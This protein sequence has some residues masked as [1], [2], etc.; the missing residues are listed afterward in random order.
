MSDN[1][2]APPPPPGRSAL[3]AHASEPPLRALRADPESDSGWKTVRVSVTDVQGI[4]A[5]ATT[6]LSAMLGVP[7]DRH[8][9]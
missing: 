8:L 3:I 7:G 6:D 4:A 5:E 1:D 2:D 9:L